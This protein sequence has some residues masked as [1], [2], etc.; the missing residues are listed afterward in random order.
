M[1]AFIPVAAPTLKGNELKYVVECL[2]SN[3]ISSQGKFVTDFEES[4]ANFIGIKHAVSVANGTVALSLALKTLGIGPGDEV[5]V[6]DFTFAATINA[7][8]HV[9]ATPVIVDIQRD[10]WCI[11]PL[12]VEKVISKKTKAIIPVHIF[13]QVVE[14]S[15]IMDLAKQHHLYIVED[16]AEALGATWEG[17]SVGAFSDIA[18]FSFFS[19]KIITTGEGGMCVTKSDQLNDRL[20]VLRDHGMSKERKYWHDEVGFNYRMT[21][22]QAAIG[23]AQMEQLDFFLKEREGIDEFYDHGFKNVP[24]FRSQLKLSRRRS[25][26][27]LKTYLLDSR[28]SVSLMIHKAKDKNIDIRAFFYPLSD[29]SIFKAYAPYFT[30]ITHEISASGFCVPTSLSFSRDDYQRV[31]QVLKEV[32]ESMRMDYFWNHDL[33]LPQGLPPN[34]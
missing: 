20:R 33:S 26:L 3:W 22:L 14:M 15:S 29:M 28:Y 6:P 21:N 30:A 32:M 12:C 16:C 27:W 7:V 25:T 4:F 9:G 34:V 1:K 23:L 13:G 18:C 17:N 19:N 5:I 8:F 24:E 2:S 11:D 10:S 31:I